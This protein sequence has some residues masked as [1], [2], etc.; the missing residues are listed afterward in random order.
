MSKFRIVHQCDKCGKIYRSDYW[1]TIY[2]GG[3]IGAA[4]VCGKCGSVGRFLEIVAKPKFF[5]L[6][7]W[8]IAKGSQK[9]NEA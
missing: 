4:M 9:R 3:V 6:C 1:P 8:I 2:N 7:G 5:G